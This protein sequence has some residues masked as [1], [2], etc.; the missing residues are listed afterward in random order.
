M[1]EVVKAEVRRAASI[2]CCMAMLELKFGRSQTGLV[3]TRF[4]HHKGLTV[5]FLVGARAA[6]DKYPFLTRNPQFRSCL[7]RGDE[8]SCSEVDCV[9]GIHQ[10]R[11]CRESVTLFQVPR[12]QT[13]PADHAV[14]L[15]NSA[16]LRSSH[17]FLACTPAIFMSTCDFVEGFVHSRR[18]LRVLRCG[19]A[20]MCAE[21]VFVHGVDVNRQTDRVPR[22]DIYPP[23]KRD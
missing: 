12:I 18:L 10:K 2:D 21:A 20:M 17:W 1:S 3:S 19:L 5:L 22:A 11:I 23:Y 7:D 6:T 9:K 15:R 4:D 8:T 13:W 16:N 14:T